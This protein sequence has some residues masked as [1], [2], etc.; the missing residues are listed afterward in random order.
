MFVCKSATSFTNTWIAINRDVCTRNVYIYIASVK[1]AAIKHTQIRI[2]FM[3]DEILEK[4]EN[5]W[6]I[7]EA[8][9]YVW[10]INASNKRRI[11]CC[12]SSKFMFWYIYRIRA[13]HRRWVDLLQRRYFKSSESVFFSRFFLDLII[14]SE[15]IF[16]ALS[17][18]FWCGRMLVTHIHTCFVC[19]FVTFVFLLFKLACSCQLNWIEFYFQLFHHS[20]QV[21]IACDYIVRTCIC[22]NPTHMNKWFIFILFLQNVCYSLLFTP[23]RWETT[24]QNEKN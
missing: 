7:F 2:I 4:Y 24:H 13:L 11:S 1:R 3:I 15:S 19:E 5:R 10:S 20:S 18:S 23:I 8:A 6:M 9:F 22:T 21:S 17:F 14:S 16:C 12:S